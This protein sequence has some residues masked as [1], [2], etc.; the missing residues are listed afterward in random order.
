MGKALEG[1][2]GFGQKLVWVWKNLNENFS[3]T[4]MG[5]TPGSR[6]VPHAAKQLSLY[7]K[8]LS[9][10]AVEPELCKKRSHWNQK[11]MNLHEEQPLLV[12]TGESLHAAVTIQSNQK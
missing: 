9:P 2:Y 1:N 12:A 6:K 4:N 8:L 7:A 3:Q 10:Q 11:P 5:S